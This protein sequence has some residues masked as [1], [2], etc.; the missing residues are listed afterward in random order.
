MSTGASRQLVWDKAMA[1]LLEMVGK[2]A[3]QTTMD[4]SVKSYDSRWSA[5]SLIKIRRGLR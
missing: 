2:P 4:N 1:L 3:S 5:T